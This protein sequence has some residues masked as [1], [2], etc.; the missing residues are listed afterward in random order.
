MLPETIDNSELVFRNVDFNPNN[1]KISENRPSSAVYKSFD[2]SVDR[3]GNRSI[4]SIIESFQNRFPNN[5]RAVL[6]LCVG[7]IRSI[8][9]EPISA[10][11]DSN[12][13]HAILTD[14]NNPKGIS[15]RKA[16]LLREMSDIY[17]IE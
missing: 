6:K 2:V 4:N 3:D 13:Y 9:I 8:S 1:W 12:P 7:S 15:S 17:Y 16:R 14:P 10:P 5:V 11:I